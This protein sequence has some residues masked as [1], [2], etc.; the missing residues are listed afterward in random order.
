MLATATRF[1]SAA[2]RSLLKPVLAS[3]TTLRS[4]SSAVQGF[5]A[6][7]QTPLIRTIASRFPAA[8]QFSTSQTTF[9][10]AD[11][12]LAKKLNEE[13]KYEK[14][15]AADSEGA[16]PS[17]EVFE[18]AG[19][20][21]VDVIGEKE[22]KLTKTEGSE[23]ITVIFSTDALAESDWSEEVE[24][25]EPESASTSVNLTVLVEKG[26]AG[27]LEF[28]VTV[29]GGEFMI[30]NVLYGKSTSLMTEETADADWKRKG[31]YG[32]P[33]FQELDEE[34]QD[35]FAK[36][37]EDRGFDESL[38]QAI[39]R[40]VEFKEQQEYQNWLKAVREFVLA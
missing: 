24:G 18:E 32:G 17:K 34:L 4:F 26:D 28:A 7:S 1:R 10:A 30:D 5:P 8:R 37:L 14:E 2:Q 22:V 3:S 13:Y 19:F 29:D 11:K 31:L 33:V 40:Y 16:G 12:D 25:E 15:S 6:L 23:K 38:A 9:A 20:K 21:I 27:T 36:Y 39:P 35:Y